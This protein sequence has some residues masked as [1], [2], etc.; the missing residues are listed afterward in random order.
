MSPMNRQ[1]GGHKAKLMAD[2]HF[3]W[4]ISWQTCRVSKKYIFRG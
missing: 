3:G 4:M 1:Q 2:Y